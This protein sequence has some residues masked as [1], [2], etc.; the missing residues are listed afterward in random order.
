MENRTENFKFKRG[1]LLN[2][3]GEM[4]LGVV[5]GLFVKV[6]RLWRG[7]YFSTLTVY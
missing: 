1:K 5:C 7:F 3:E 4:V 6:Y 2:K